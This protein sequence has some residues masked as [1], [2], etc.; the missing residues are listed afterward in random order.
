MEIKVTTRQRDYSI[1]IEH[2]LLKRARSLIG[3]GFNVFIP[4]RPLRKRSL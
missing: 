4:Q 2:G 1:F 3:D